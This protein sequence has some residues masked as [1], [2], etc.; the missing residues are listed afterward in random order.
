MTFR[1]ELIFAGILVIGAI[2]L[3][4]DHAVRRLRGWACSWQEGLT[5]QAE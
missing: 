2:G 5:A 1:P 3:A 4:G